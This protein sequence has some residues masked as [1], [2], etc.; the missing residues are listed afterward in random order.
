MAEL[1]VTELEF[2]TIKENLKNFLRSQS[3]F[4][5]YDFDGAGLS[6]L[7]DVLA[8]NTH[9]N[10]TLSHLLAN[11]MFI[12]SAVKRNSI[13]SIAK[14]LGYTPRSRRS[15]RAALSMV[16]SPALSYSS[17]SL[18][19]PKD[20]VFTASGNNRSY[21]FYPIQDYSS[22]RTTNNLGQSQFEFPE[23]ILIEGKR[24][25][26]T[27]IVDQ[28]NISGPFVL[29]N[30]N[31][32]T[33]TI[34]VRVLDSV[35]VSDV[36]TFTPAST[37]ID[38]TPNSQIFFIE[39]GPEG[40]Y[41]IRFGDGVIGSQ[42]TVGNVV[43]VDYIVSSGSLP[44][45]VG[46]TAASSY[47]CSATLTGSSETKSITVLA[48]ASGGIEKESIDEIR[49][50]APKFNTTRNRA[51]TVDDYKN[52]I[53]SQYGPAIN[54]IAVW[55]G[56]E[57]VP[58][59]YGKVFVSIEPLPGTVLTQNDYDIITRD[60]I[61]PRSVV[62]IQPEYVDPEYTYIGLDVT[63]KY[64][65]T[66]TTFT[67]A[68]IE[69]EVNTVI[70]SF[71]ENNLNKLESN[72]YYSKLSKAILETTSSVYSTNIEVLLY[73]VP[74]VITGF[75]VNFQVPYNIQLREGSVRST[76]FR[77]TIVG[78][79]Y[80]VYLT[81]DGNGNLILKT[82]AED[83]TLPG[84]FG[85]VD[86]TTGLLSVNSFTIDSYLGSIAQ[87][88]IYAKPESSSP[89]IIVGNL[90]RV[91]DVSTS[92]VF[93]YASRNTVLKLDTSSNDSG[94]GIPNGLVITAIPSVQE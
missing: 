41:E 34:Q 88:R 80:E 78:V 85:S 89:D 13:V 94:S 56:E 53:V 42:L 5:D 65:S 47:T 24:A 3:E 82:T 51:V 73:R 40:L 2:Q 4:A 8:Y 64:N 79:Q 75:S 57:N 23:I 66:Q 31:V 29:P 25:T 35:T 60:I 19:L 50:N 58:P 37:I 91:S 15:S 49:F 62:S 1:R 83:T 7:L 20:T 21:T 48:A 69:Q 84:I 26:N 39:E 18:F 28:S 77:T 6:I 70:T 38:H 67:P 44:N 36:R 46:T 32:D 27:F 86:Y 76:N 71:F 90:R 74:T 9:Y 17:T 30:N 10:A 68:R 93:A 52:L 72:F 12:D 61:G 63:V 11:E 55:G 43:I 87:F 59:I 33:S 54:S 81:D 16:V 22:I 14:T 92:A 45:Y